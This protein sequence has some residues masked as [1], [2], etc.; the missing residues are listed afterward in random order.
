MGQRP[1]W[2]PEDGDKTKAGEQVEETEGTDARF[3]PE[4]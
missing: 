4:R 2:A 3:Q 1:L